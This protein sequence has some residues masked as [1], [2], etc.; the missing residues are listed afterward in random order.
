MAASHDNT[1][2]I[3]CGERLANAP[4]LKGQESHGSRGPGRIHTVRT[5]RRSRSSC[6][7]QGS[8]WAD[9]RDLYLLEPNSPVVVM[10]VR[11]VC[12]SHPYGYHVGSC[13]WPFRL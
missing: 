5:Y 8:H 2:K 4:R 7:I 6:E 10:H 9:G 13:S 3:T 11:F 1:S 12:L